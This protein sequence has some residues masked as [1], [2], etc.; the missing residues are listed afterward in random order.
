M[1]T[2]TIFRDAPKYISQRFS[3]INNYVWQ[4][5]FPDNS[6]N[7]RLRRYET[8]ELSKLELNRLKDIANEASLVIFI[9]LLKRFFAEGTNAAIQAVDTFNELGVNGF[10]IGSKFFS[11]RNENVMEGQLL[12]DTLMNTIT[13]QELIT[14]INDSQYVSQIVTRYRDIIEG[15]G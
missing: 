4:S 6:L 9:F 7:E 10:Q 1:D 5:F 14:L 12:A 8:E 13:N 2:T 11:G 15:N 3:A